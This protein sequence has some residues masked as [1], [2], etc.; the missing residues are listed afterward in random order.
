M[1]EAQLTMPFGG[2]PAVLYGA[3]SSR[4][5]LCL[6]GKCGFKE[7][8]ASFAELACPK[9]WQVLAI[10]LPAPLA[11]HFFLF[12]LTSLS[13]LPNVCHNRAISSHDPGGLSWKRQTPIVR[14][15]CTI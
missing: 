9:G 2:I 5:W 1:N 12:P 11:A 15:T 8:A 3:P 7:E 14:K 10:D 6:H 4:V 13:I